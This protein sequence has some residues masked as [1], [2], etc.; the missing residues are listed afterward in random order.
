MA[1][2]SAIIAPR[3]VTRAAIHQGFAATTPAPVVI[4]H[5]LALLTGMSDED[6]MQIA[7][8][9]PRG[10]MKTGKHPTQ[11][12]IPDDVLDSAKKKHPEITNQSQL[13]RYALALAAGFTDDEAT[14][15]ASV[16]R[17]RKR[18]SADKPA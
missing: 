2:I 3:G 7:Q 12:T 10:T 6:A 13:V 8:P 17:G 9:A 5:A 4:R 14:D 1:L 16:K 11:V 18:N 15:Y